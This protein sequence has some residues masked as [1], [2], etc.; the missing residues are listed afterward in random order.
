MTTREQNISQSRPFGSRLL[1]AATLAGSLAL[2]GNAAAQQT[3]VHAKVDFERAELNSADG[4]ALV[5]ERVQRAAYE[6]CRVHG[7][8]GMQRLR[9]EQPCR[10]EMEAKLLAAID[11]E[12][13]N[14][15]HAQYRSR[16]GQD[17]G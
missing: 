2:A 14:Q 13:L 3:E 10:T 9:I 12:R 7:V 6:A 11:S 17:A 5:H 1:V 8:R 16:S 15:F 4:L